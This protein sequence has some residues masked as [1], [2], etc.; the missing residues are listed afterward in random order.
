MKVH[1]IKRKTIEKYEE[2]NARSRSSFKLW[3]LT[4]KGVD[5][6]NPEDILKTFGS[7]DL[8]GMDLIA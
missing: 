5:W 7:A 2:N 1:L 3:E 8:L 4:L 6:H